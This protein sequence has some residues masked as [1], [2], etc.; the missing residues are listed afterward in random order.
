MTVS[1]N[2]NTKKTIGMINNNNKSQLFQCKCLFCVSQSLLSSEVQI[3]SICIFKKKKT[4]KKKREERTENMPDHAV[5]RQQ[6]GVTGPRKAG[7][8]CPPAEANPGG[9]I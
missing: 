2:I 7:A 8:P 1:K 6:Q 5:Y 9:G 3:T 4:K